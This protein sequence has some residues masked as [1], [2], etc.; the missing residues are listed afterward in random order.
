MSGRRAAYGHQ[1]HAI[2][3]PGYRI[4]EYSPTMLPGKSTSHDRRTLLILDMT[5]S[6]QHL[7]CRCH[8]VLG[9][10]IERSV[11]ILLIPCRF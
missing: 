4:T 2:Q 10:Q 5:A 8:A 6:Y 1:W 9:M 7:E 3:L 11:L